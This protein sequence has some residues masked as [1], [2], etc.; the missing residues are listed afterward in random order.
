MNTKG[1]VWLGALRL[2]TL[3]LAAGG[4]ILGSLLPEVS[5]NLDARIFVLA[6]LTAFS[7]QILSNLANDY[8]DHIKGTDNEKR[9]GPQ[10]A[11]QSGLISQSEMKRAM[12]ICGIIALFSGITLILLSFGAGQM[13]Q[14]LS[15]LAIG[16]VAIW[17]SIRYTVGKR[18][19]GY[20][21]LGDV[22]VLLFFGLVS[23]WGVSFLYMGALL[24]SLLFPALSYGLLAVGVLN[25]N[26]MRDI[27]N[28]REANKRTLVVMMGLQKAKVYHASLIL[29][30]LFCQFYYL[31]NL[32]LEACFSGPVSTNFNLRYLGL[33][34]FLPIAINT[35]KVLKPKTNSAAYN[36]YLKG[37]AIGALTQALLLVTV[38]NYLIP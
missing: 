2:R 16:L 12:I 21:G 10:R 7:L 15:M 11:M 37:L 36:P 19:Y 4:I 33:L 23:V 35:I 22:F 26:N 18:P 38:L 24:P 34:G 20:N 8:G 25:I 13:V 14:A 6:L 5:I 27:D 17:A 9:V 31:W 29:L 30:A 28:D 32:N 1:K 3:P